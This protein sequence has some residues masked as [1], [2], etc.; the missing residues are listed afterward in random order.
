MK[1]VFI[2]GSSGTTGLRIRQRLSERDDVSL[3]VLPDELKHDDSAR[4]DAVNDSDITILCLPD[5]VSREIVKKCSDADTVIIDTSTAHRTDPKWIYGFPELTGQ[6]QRISCSKRIANPGC[7]A[8]GFISLT[9]PL[10]NAGVIDADADLSY[11]SLT[12][13]TGGG[14]KMIAE[15]EK[16]DRNTEFDAP[17]IY[18]VSQEHKHLPEMVMYSGLRSAPVFVPVV[19]SF[20]TGMLGVLP[21]HRR[22]IDADIDAVKRIYQETYRYGAVVFSDG[23]DDRFSLSASFLS[24]SDGLLIRVFG[25]NDRIILTA[26]FDNLGKGACGAAIQNLNI[27]LGAD[28]SKGLHFYEA[29]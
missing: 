12:G 24:G 17:L 3:I 5:D 20:P 27:V 18:S 4:A 26:A 14:K 13:Y 16:K 11:F 22:D 28:E 7:H 1:K 15:Y 25:N 2:D 19:A 10:V 6:R 8:T 29:H 21:L 9:A 23:P